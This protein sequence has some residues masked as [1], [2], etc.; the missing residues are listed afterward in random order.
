[1]KRLHTPII[2]AIIALIV[3]FAVQ[4]A[5]TVEV[6]FLFW[7]MALPRAV[8]LFLIFAVGVVTG[9]IIARRRRQDQDLG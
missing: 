3:V 7:S 6:S 8:L 9:L 5:T 1:M 2:M 4:N